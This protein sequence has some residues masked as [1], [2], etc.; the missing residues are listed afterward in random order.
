MNE[1]SHDF[2]PSWLTLAGIAAALL[3]L[4][5]LVW[6]DA[7]RLPAQQTVGVGP[8]ASMHLIAALVAVLGLAHAVAALRS[9]FRAVEGHAPRTIG[10]PHMG[11]LVWV[12]GGLGG[13]VGMIELGGGF[14]L[15]AA[16]LF[17]AT[18]KAFGQRLGIKSLSIGLILAIAVFAFFTQVL[19]L[20]LPAGPLE[21]FI[22]G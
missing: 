2:G 5:G 20:S 3:M 1:P 6:A 8:A 13:L 19:S 9:Y 4:A 7:S 12:L 18:A 15:G 17:A 10:M 16:W 14:V 21:H 22:S 11:G